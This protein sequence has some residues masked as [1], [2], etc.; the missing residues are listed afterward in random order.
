M[1]QYG[2]LYCIS[3]LS[4]LMPQYGLLHSNDSSAVVDARSEFL[5]V[6]W[7]PQI[8]DH[9]ERNVPRWPARCAS[10]VIYIHWHTHCCVTIV[11][12][13]Y[14][15]SP[16]FPLFHLCLSPIPPLAHLLPP[17]I[18]TFF[19]CLFSETDVIVTACLRADERAFGGTGIPGTP[20]PSGIL[21]CVVEDPIEN[22]PK[23]RCHRLLPS[24]ISAICAAF[25]VS[26]RSSR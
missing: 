5:A 21:Q 7:V 24:S 20:A 26:C 16:A 14:L 9:L 6:G 3:F 25:A 2:L 22:G 11:C 18:L 19:I 10:T 17:S 15:C 4:A 12:I 8:R 1:P 23:V 13:I